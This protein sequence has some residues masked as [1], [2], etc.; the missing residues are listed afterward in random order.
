[1]WANWVSFIIGLWFFLSGLVPGLQAEWNMV[2][3]GIAAV[4]FGFIAYESW[5]GIANGIIGIWMFLSG[6]WFSL[7]FPW[8]FLIF[9]AAMAILGAWGASTQQK[10]GTISH[11]TA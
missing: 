6:V 1:M 3:L 11:G 2:I 5:Q 8:N 9:G 4:I 10:A 7:I